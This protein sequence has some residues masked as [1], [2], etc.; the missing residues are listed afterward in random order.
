MRNSDWSSD[1]CSSDL[2]TLCALLDQM[3]NGE[4]VRQYSVQVNPVE[5]VVRQ[6]TDTIASDDSEV[7]KAIAFIHEN[8][9]RSISVEEVAQV[10]TISRRQLANR[11]RDRK[12]TRLNSSH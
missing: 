5:V 1:V 2:S 7:I 8:K 4:S 6:S 12:S 11:F 10:T 9:H 3:M